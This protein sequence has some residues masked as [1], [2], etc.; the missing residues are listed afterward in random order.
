SAF[1]ARTLV[2]DGE[3]I[4]L[5][6]DG[7][8]RPFQETGARAATRTTGAPV[9]L[10]LFVFDVLHADGADVL[11]LPLSQR[12]TVL[13]DV[14]PDEHRVPSIVTA[15]PAEAAAFFDE[16]VRLGHE[17]VVAKSLD[18]PYEA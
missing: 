10:S 15:S 4:A 1:P 17:G 2:L 5:R 13:G 16:T 7:R 12:R 9:P 14:V 3:A 11:D 18:A 8:P 6:A